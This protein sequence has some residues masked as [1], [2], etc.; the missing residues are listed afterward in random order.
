MQ[1]KKNN[2]NQKI[3]LQKTQLELL[4]TK[5]T[6]KLRT[7]YEKKLEDLVHKNDEIIKAFAQRD[8]KKLDRLVQPYFDSLIKENPNFEII[9]FGLPNST[10]FYRA[11]MPRKYGDD[12][13]KVQGVKQVNS[14][15]ERTSGFM[16]AKLGLYYRTTIPVFY[17]GKYIGLIAFGV[18]LNYINDFI[19]D[20]IGTQSAVIVKTK[21]FKKSKWFEMLEEGTIGRYTIISTNGELI[22]KM[23]SNVEVDEKDLRINVNG[24]DYSVINDINIYDI[25]N[26]NV[27][28][29]ILFQDITKEI[30]AY[31]IYLY[32]AIA[33]LALLIF[34]LMFVLVRIF[35]EFLSTII[36]INDNLQELNANLEERVEEEVKKNRDKEKQLYEQSK[37][38]QLGEMIENIAHQWRQPLAVISAA[39]S[40]MKIQKEV[41]FLNDEDFIK[42]SD[43]VVNI[44]QHLSDTIEDFMGFIK[45]ERNISKF[46][47]QKQ[48]DK[49]LNIVRDTLINSHI[50]LIKNYEEEQIEMNSISGE[51]SQVILNIINNAKDILIERKIEDKKVYINISKKGSFALITIEDNAGGIPNEILPK[52]FDP[53]FTTKHQL[54]GTGIGLYMSTSIVSGSL[55][56]KL[57]AKNSL[58]GAKFYIEIPID[59]T[60]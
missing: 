10:A 51:L 49:A 47:L 52:I 19:H 18:N 38:A 3:L 26:K 28:K 59:I 40:G 43:K 60:K 39:V 48:I 34:T 32:T 21:E 27:A 54:H 23:P 14:L 50:K 57:Y 25:D 45:E 30:E 41:G 36:T 42:T 7:T 6:I 12:I 31:K 9:C 1:D 2:I 8:K 44:T 13:S 33:V 16:L 56:G 46:I 37:R 17:E 35:N 5:R 58:N 53:Y 4:F 15:K 55:K 20:E 24:R 29:V 22:N 11:H